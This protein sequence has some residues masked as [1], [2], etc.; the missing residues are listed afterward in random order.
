MTYSLMSCSKHPE[1]QKAGKD[2]IMLRTVGK[3]AEIIVL[4]VKEPAAILHFNL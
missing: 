1:T 4:N 2:R 3:S